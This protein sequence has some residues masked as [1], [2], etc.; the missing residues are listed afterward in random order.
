MV[1]TGN[2]AEI[3][4]EPSEPD[5]TD[6]IMTVEEAEAYTKM[7]KKTFW[8]AIKMGKLKMCKVG[9]RV[10]Y[11]KSDIDAWINAGRT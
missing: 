3:H 4:I 2:Y 8:R 11:R 1:T 10:L 9:R 5:P 6:E 7:E